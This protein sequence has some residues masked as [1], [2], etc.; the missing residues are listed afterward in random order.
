[1]QR[2]EN[3]AEIRVEH[4]AEHIA[5]IPVLALWVKK[6]WG[7][8]MPDVTFEAF[9]S[10][11]E[12]RTTYHKVPETFVA[13]QG[14]KLLGMASIDKHDMLIGMELTP[15]LAAVYVAPEFRNQGIGSR[16][17]Q[18]VMQEAEILGLEKLYLLTPDKE[19][20]YSRLDWKVFEYTHYRGEDVVIMVYE[21]RNQQSRRR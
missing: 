1:M 9:H 10:T 2:E 21:V 12:E 20:F 5:F 4:L 11:F 17:V 16:L 15:W 14:D 19:R 13:V 8:L 7:H 6:E 3:R 18:T